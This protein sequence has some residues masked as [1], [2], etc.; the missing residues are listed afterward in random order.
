MLCVLVIGQ[1]QATAAVLRSR[2]A[3]LGC[4]VSLLPGR[5][6]AE[7]LGSVDDLSVVVIDEPTRGPGGL[8]ALTSLRQRRPELPIV[9][10]S[11]DAEVSDRVA[12][13]DAGATDFLAKP[14]SVAELIARVHAQ[15]RRAE[16]R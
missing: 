7:Q 6:D 14:F 3:S 12:A 8:E 11:A 4:E 15:L 9:V 5:I 16:W 13:F 1:D 10:L 2:M